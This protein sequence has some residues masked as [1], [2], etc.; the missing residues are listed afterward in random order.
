MGA[1][2]KNLASEIVHSASK[3][4]FS[5]IQYGSLPYHQQTG[6]SS[7]PGYGG[8]AAWIAIRSL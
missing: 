1:Q 5:T 3:V 6:I 2:K 4:F 7:A 8:V